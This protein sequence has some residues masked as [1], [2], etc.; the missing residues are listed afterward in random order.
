GSYTITVTIH[1]EGAVLDAVVT[2]KATVATLLNHALGFGG[3][4]NSLVIGSALP[5]RTVRG[6]PA[7]KQTGALTDTVQGMINKKIQINPGT[8]GKTFTGFNTITIYGQAGNDDLEV[9]D[10]VKKNAALFGRDGNDRLKGGAGKDTL[11]GE[12]GNDRLY[13]GGGDNTLI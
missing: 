3:D 2:T 7:G 1:H 5:A 6:G 11:F 8:G 12:A 9:T 13:A 10:G 4:T